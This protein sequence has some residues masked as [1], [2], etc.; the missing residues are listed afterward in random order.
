MPSKSAI[1]KGLKTFAQSQKIKK[2]VGVFCGGTGGIGLSTAAAFVRATVNSPT[3]PTIYIVGRNPSKANSAK[4]H[5]TQFNPNLSFHFLQHDLSLLKES[6]I[7]ADTV[8][9]NESHINLLSLTQGGFP[10]PGQTITSEG[11]DTK[12]ATTY[13]SRMLILENLVSLLD[14]AAVDKGEPAA[15]LT[16]MSGG[17]ER[18]SSIDPS[19]YGL[20]KK[21]SYAKIMTLPQT[22]LSLGMLKLA[23]T[24]PHVMFVHTFPGLVKTDVFRNL[25][26]YWRAVMEGITKLTGYDPEVSGEAHL[27]GSLVSSALEPSGNVHFFN[28]SMDEAYSESVRAK[29]KDIFDTRIQDDLWNHTQETFEKVLGTPVN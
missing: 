22:Y 7:V 9:Q 2:P 11:L 8:L 21:Y 27:Y 29:G 28:G 18:V 5:L 24:H 13:Y 26:W 19:D 17:R 20:V 15:A 6:K 3:P 12:L 25:P 4:A 23:R 10:A 16:V 1:A 14:T